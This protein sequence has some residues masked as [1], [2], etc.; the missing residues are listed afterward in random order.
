MDPR[1]HVFPYVLYVYTPH[2]VLITMFPLIAVFEHLFTITGPYHT[3]P[4]H[5]VPHHTIT[6]HSNQNP[7]WIPENM[8]S[9]MYCMF[10]HHIWSW[11]LCSP[12]L[13]CLNIFSIL[14]GQTIPYHTIP[15]RTVPYHSNRN[16]R[17]PQK[18]CLPLCSHTIFGSDYY[19]LF[20]RNSVQLPM[21]PGAQLIV[22][23]RRSHTQSIGSG[24]FTWLIPQQ[25]IVTG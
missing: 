5:T 4:Y 9:L 13:L 2:L 24:R 21:H 22:V 23:V 3:I 10:T 8:Y 12:W 7:R 18:L 19:V 15:Y 25:D 20:P 17:W 14:L 16:P 6:Y 1:K 11:L